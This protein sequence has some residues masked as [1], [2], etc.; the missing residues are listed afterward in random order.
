MQKLKQLLSLGP[1]SLPSFSLVAYAYEDSFPYKGKHTLA[2]SQ[3]H[4]IALK[5]Y[6][7]EH[8]SSSS[9]P[10]PGHNTTQDV[11]KTAQVGLLHCKQQAE[12]QISVHQVDLDAFG[13]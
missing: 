7:T 12:H 8:A 3:P 1:D 9:P 13:P 2:H 11:P 4:N 6:H 10:R 5:S